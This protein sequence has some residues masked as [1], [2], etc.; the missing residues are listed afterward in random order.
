MADA[1]RI[2]HCCGCGIG[3]WPQLPFD[4]WPGNLHMSPVQPKERKKEKERE[5]KERKGEERRGEKR[6]GEER[7]GE[8]R[9]GEERK[10][11]ER[12][13]VGYERT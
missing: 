10:G 13:G 11:K 6:R 7:R 5:G 12:R 3:W 1:A 8:E 2:Q 9:R 4:P